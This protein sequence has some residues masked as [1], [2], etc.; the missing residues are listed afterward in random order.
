MLSF[1][2]NDAPNLCYLHTLTAVLL[3][4]VIVLLPPDEQSRISCDTSGTPY[5]LA[6]ET[7]KEELLGCPV[8]M[9]AAGVILY[10]LLVRTLRYFNVL[11][12]CYVYISLNCRLEVYPSGWEK[13]VRE[14]CSGRL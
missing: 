5:Y 12:S 14:R 4:I 8:D 11:L 9:W 6:P 3:V 1:D 13:R 2:A 7:L 10:V